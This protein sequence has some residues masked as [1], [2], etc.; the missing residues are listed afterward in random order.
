MGSVVADDGVAVVD[1]VVVLLFE[2]GA[3]VVRDF[4]GLSEGAEGVV[5]DGVSDD[6]EVGGVGVVVGEQCGVYGFD[7]AEVDVVVVGHDAAAGVA[8]VV[9]V[10]ADGAFDGGVG[11]VGGGVEFAGG[12][13]H[14][15]AGVG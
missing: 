8:E 15:D 13:G 10:A 6:D 5:D 12:E 4:E 3:G 11:E 2:D 7:S 1:A 9:V 14:S